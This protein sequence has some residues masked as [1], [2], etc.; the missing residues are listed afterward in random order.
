M[1]RLLKK[2][3]IIIKQAFIALGLC[4]V[5]LPVAVAQIDSLSENYSQPRY[6]FHH[7][8]FRIEYVAPTVFMTYGL[9]SI[10]NP[11]VRSQVMNIKLELQR[12][13]PKKFPVDDYSQYMATAAF[14]GLEYAGIP[15]KH[16]LKQRL[17]T[18]SVSHII[19]GSVVNLMKQT[20]PV[21]RPDGS[22]QNS[23]PSG[24]TATAFVGAEL[25]WQ[26]YHDRSLWY[27]VAGYAVAAG[28]GFFRMYNNKH[29]LSDVAMG[30]GIG[31]MSTKI[32]YWM[33]PMLDKQKR[34]IP[35]N[36]L[37]VPTYDGKHSGISL[38]VNL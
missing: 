15:A 31:I 14:L 1:N 36:Y 8:V 19:M 30:A 7:K 3:S 22:A 17:F 37:L 21:M 16:N 27:G 28:T 2:S 29:W 38:L 5:D 20:M 23:F 18:G 34:I 35:G 13:H 33:L 24:H 25:L 32:A 11:V 10:K 9:M 4:C 26:E 6:G 12:N